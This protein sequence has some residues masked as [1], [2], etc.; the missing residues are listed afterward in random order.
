VLVGREAEVAT[1]AAGV[2]RSESVVVCGEA[3]I[4]KTV[5]VQEVLSRADRTV[6]VAQC[7]RLLADDADLVLRQVLGAVPPGDVTAV[8]EALASAVGDGVLVV[9]DAQWAH[10]R[11]LR[12]LQA[13]T[14]RSCVVMTVRAGDAGAEDALEAAAAAVRIELPPLPAPAMRAIV[15]GA[16]PH[17]PA[18]EVEAVAAATGGN[19]LLAEEAAR[20][21]TEGG[22]VQQVLAAH[23][24]GLTD[25]VRDAAVLVALA[26]EPLPRAVVGAAADDLVARHLAVM[27]DDQL[28]VRHA[29]LSDAIARTV[30]EDACAA[31]HLRLA[32]HAQEAGTKARHLAAGG[33]RS[34][35][36]AIAEAAAAQTTAP[37][38][39]AGLLVVA[40]RQVDVS[41]PLTEPDRQ[42]VLAAAD[43]AA[44][45]LGDPEVAI[46][47]LGAVRVDDLDAQVDILGRRSALLT[48]AGRPMESYEVNRE[49]AVL[50]ASP[51]SATELRVLLARAR[52][53]VSEGSFADAAELA[54]TAAALADRVDEPAH[55][56]LM[57]LGTCRMMAGL[58]DWDGPLREGVAR[59]SERGHVQDEVRLRSQLILGLSLTDEPPDALI[60][61]IVSAREVAAAAGLRQQ[62]LELTVHLARHHQLAG[63]NEEALGI[64]DALVEGAA[65]PA[66]K[67]GAYE[68]IGSALLALGLVDELCERLDPV[69]A[70]LPQ[71]YNSA[72]TILWHLARAHIEAGRP[73]VALERL[74]MADQLF[75]P[76]QWYADATTGAIRAWARFDLA[77]DPGPPADLDADEAQMGMDEVRALHLDH[78]GLRALHIGD[79]GAAVA[80]FRAAADAWEAEGSALALASSWAL[81][82]A[83]TRSGETD[84]ARVV[85]LAVEEEAN[86]RFPALLP[87]V[88]RSLRRL[89]EGRPDEVPRRRGQAGLTPRE[90][91]VLELVG[92]GLS[93][94]AIAQRLGTSARTVD[95][96]VA[97][98]MTKLGASSRRHAA[99]VV[100]GGR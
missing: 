11:T 60:G 64:A 71:S 100:T 33:R 59:A 81:A 85:L 53:C 93:S 43:A 92:S 24:G 97:S 30:G 94:R 84:E 46:D 82:E 19:P 57:I 37:T 7:L 75:A 89:G 95:S 91:E 31:A 29:L 18:A 9:E 86:R 63:R 8:A 70:A 42:L 14:E 25:E 4:G 21:G 20:H 17:L 65:H 6:R 78:E 28:H 40:A 69:I 73:A 2:D 61:E 34:E 52:V 67:A 15:R 13:V 58:D 22:P 88:R 83:L 16:A 48:V 66:V 12:V 32:A 72:L 51:G 47:L 23:L 38:T 44:E 76:Q 45:S 54:E 3:G 80:A 5:L 77:Q 68:V 1:L 56:A 26:T 39:R 36:R 87:R 79:C 49:M 98:A 41:R 10:P 74:Q 50:E 96:Q 35:A 99:L 62:E 27:Q 90:T 55:T